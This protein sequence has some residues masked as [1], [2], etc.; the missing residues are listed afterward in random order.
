MPEKSLE[1]KLRQL[2]RYLDKEKYLLL[3]MAQLKKDFILSGLDFDY[4]EAPENLYAFLQEQITLMLDNNIEALRNLLYRIDV[5]VENIFK[6]P[7][8]NIVE[9]IVQ[10]IIKR[11]LQKVII[12][13]HYRE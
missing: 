11:S 2:D 8:S 6:N 3:T 10:E 7:S 12:R 13:E 1:E 5:N 4:H 9:K